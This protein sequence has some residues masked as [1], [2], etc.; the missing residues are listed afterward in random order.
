M[1]Y[2]NLCVFKTW[3]CLKIRSLCQLHVQIHIRVMMYDLGCVIVF[4]YKNPQFCS[5]M[6]ENVNY[7]YICAFM[8]DNL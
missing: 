7:V 4:F 5:E 3:V 8:N 2:V 1:K 6:C